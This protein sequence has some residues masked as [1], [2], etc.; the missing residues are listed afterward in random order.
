MSIFLPE[1][2][3]LFLHIPRTGGSWVDAA[4][5]KA[6]I[7]VEKWTR[8]GPW[9][10]PRKHTILLHYQLNLLE[11]IHYVFCFVRHPVSYYVSLWRFYARIAPWNGERLKK[12]KEELPPRATDEAVLRWKPDFN[13]WLDEVLEEEPGWVTR[14]YEQFIGPKRGEFCHYIGRQETLEDDFSEVMDI[15]GYGEIWEQ[16]KNQFYA[17]MAKRKPIHWIP[18]SRVPYIEVTDEQRKRIERSE[19]VLL[20]RFYGED[21]SEKRIYRNF[22]TGEP[23]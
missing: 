21:T 14:W 10:R 20:R 8:V 18:E 2:Q 22:Q 9:Y 5:N 23:V 17:E 12:Y 7:P 16:K 6:K 4:M 15:I 1:K 19:R 11:K 3:V 13:Q